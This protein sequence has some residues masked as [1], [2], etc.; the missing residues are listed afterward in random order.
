[1]I[2]H[3]SCFSF[4]E[5]CLSKS[6]SG[7]EKI[8]DEGRFLLIQ[9]SNCLTNIEGVVSEMCA[10][11]RH[12]N[13]HGDGHLALWLRSPP[14]AQSLYV[15]AE[16]EYFYVPPYVGPKGW[17]GVDLDKGVLRLSFVHYTSAAEVTQLIEALENVLAAAQH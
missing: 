12:I 11:T 5:F 7:L 9:D 15:D 2:L 10:N 1:M 6:S 17:L 4:I 8:S 14:G 3:K 16:P 13:H